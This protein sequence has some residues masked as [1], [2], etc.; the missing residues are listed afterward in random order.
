MSQFA[1]F[2]DAANSAPESDAALLLPFPLEH[3]ANTNIT[4]A[5]ASTRSGIPT[6]RSFRTQIAAAAGAI[7]DVLFMSMPRFRG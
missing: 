4:E 7:K 5:I 6:F 2:D 3:A 1:S